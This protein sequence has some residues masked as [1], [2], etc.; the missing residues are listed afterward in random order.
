MDIY[1]RTIEAEHL[2]IRE[3]SETAVMSRIDRTT[4]MTAVME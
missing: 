4:L 3:L 1:G 2:V